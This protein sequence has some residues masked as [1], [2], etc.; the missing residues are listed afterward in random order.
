MISKSGITFADKWH[1]ER[2]W[3]LNPVRIY[4]S[5]PEAKEQLIDIPGGDGAIDLTEIN[6]RPS[7]GMRSVELEYDLRNIDNQQWQAIF[8]EIGTAITGRKV[9]M[10]LDDEPEHYYMTRLNADGEK[11]DYVNGEITLSGSAEPFKYDLLSSGEPWLWDIFN[12]QTGVIR[13]LMDVEITSTDRSVTILGAGID[14]PPVF[15]VTEAN[16]LQLIHGG[17]TYTLKVGRN[18]F[19]AVRVGKEDVTLTFSGTG[20]LSIEYRGRYL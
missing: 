11:T 6:G 12:F 20:K 17:R 1:T 16:N 15:V 7:Y 18:R 4:I 3:H 5:M 8:S 10:V 14:N 9:K 13:T 2:D 19:P